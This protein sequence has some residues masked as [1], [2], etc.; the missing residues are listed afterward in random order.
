M[1]FL[2]DQYPKN[3]IEV[4]SAKNADGLSGMD[5]MEMNL[6]K[7]DEGLII[8]A[9]MNVETEIER[10][11]RDYDYGITEEE[12]DYYAKHMITSPL[13]AQLVFHFWGKNFGAYRN[14]NN[15]GRRD[16]I[17][18]ALTLKRILLMSA[19]IDDSGKFNDSTILPYILTGN[20]Q[21]KINTRIIRNNKYVSKVESSY[22]YQ[23][24]EKNKYSNLVKI[25][26]E[27]ILSLLSQINNTTFTYVVYEDQNL[28]GQPIEYNEDK[29]SDEMLF[30]IYMI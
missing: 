8:L 26:Q 6:Q 12:I 2:K 9:E 23:E 25:K 28:L 24:I 30:L 16:Y 18:L 5:K 20:L 11:R 13:Q 4:T 27:Y 21:D 17:F 15:I 29:L 3:L 1:Y 7:I 10:I 19:G 22:L 14:T